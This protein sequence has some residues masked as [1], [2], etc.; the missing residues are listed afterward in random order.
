MPSPLA[1]ASSACHTGGPAVETSSKYSRPG[2]VEE[3]ELDFV[4]R[5]GGPGTA[6]WSA[7][8]SQKRVGAFVE[9]LAKKEFELMTKIETVVNQELEIVQLALVDQI[10]IEFAGLALLGGE[11]MVEEEVTVEEG[12]MVRGKKGGD[13][14]ELA[15][16]G[17][18]PGRASQSAS[19]MPAERLV[20]AS[21]HR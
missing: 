5:E 8:P 2:T 4:A 12:A 16:L 10:E 20:V 17:S 21:R 18:K 7:M 1:V 15:G 14:M 3:N 19:A 13:L 9:M 11:A 6:R